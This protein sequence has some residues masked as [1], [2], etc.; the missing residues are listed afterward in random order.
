MYAS[1][2][3]CVQRPDQNRWVQEQGLLVLLLSMNTDC[4]AFSLS[5]IDSSPVPPVASINQLLALNLSTL[6]L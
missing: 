3:F 1:L 5:E 2:C 4:A 6:N